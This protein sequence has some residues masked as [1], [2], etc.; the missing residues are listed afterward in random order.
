MGSKATHRPCSNRQS[1][2]KD[3]KK[4]KTL[5]EVAGNM[6]SDMAE[7]SLEERMKPARDAQQALEDEIAALTFGP[8]WKEEAAE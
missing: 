6:L 8:R 4:R 3:L 1:A 7:K 5:K 2:P